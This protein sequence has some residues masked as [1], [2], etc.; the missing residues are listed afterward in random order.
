[1]LIGEKNNL[2]WSFEECQDRDLQ[3]MELHG[4]KMKCH[5]KIGMNCSNKNC[6]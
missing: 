3:A 6:V 2:N 4:K 5:L 1:M